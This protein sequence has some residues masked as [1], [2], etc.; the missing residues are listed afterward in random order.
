MRY[1]FNK[2]IAIITFAAI[3]IVFVISAV[4]SRFAGDRELPLL[5]ILMYWVLGLFAV[6]FSGLIKGDEKTYPK[7][8]KRDKNEK[9]KR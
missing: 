1:K 7:K 4:V 9:Q 6:I 2:E 3:T 8:Y 5:G